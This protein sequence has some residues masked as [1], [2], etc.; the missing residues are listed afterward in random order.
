M[1]YTERIQMRDK[2]SHSPWLGHFFI[3]FEQS[4]EKV[5][6]GRSRVWHP[7]TDVYETDSHVMV[8]IEVAGV[9]E[10]DLVV[11]LQGRVLTVYGC[12]DDPSAKLSYQQ[13]EINY[14]DFRSEVTLPC[15]VDESGVRADYDRGFLY[16]LLPKLQREHK[17]PVVVVNGR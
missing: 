15:D 9:S 1:L 3:S 13:M 8:K 4:S 10:D 14:G 2:E 6:L 5:Y 11:R 7:P 16:I 17:V 12:R